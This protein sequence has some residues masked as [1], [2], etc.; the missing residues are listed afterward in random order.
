VGAELARLDSW[1]V[2][3]VRHVHDHGEVGLEPVRHHAR[4]VGADLLLHSRHTGDR[5]GVTAGLLH[6][7]RHLD[8]HE[9]AEPIVERPRDDPLAPQLDRFGGDDDLVAG[10][11]ERA[12]LVAVLRADVDVE[13]LHLE[14]LLAL[15]G[16][17]EVR[18]LAADDPGQRP[19]ASDHVDALPDQDLPVPAAGLDHAQVALV[20]HVAHEQRDLVDVP[21]DRHQR[22]V[23][24]AVNAGDGRPELVR[25]DLVREP[26]GGL[27]PDARRLALVSGRAGRGQQAV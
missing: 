6:A 21:D 20:G 4:A 13:V 15:V 23:A 18:R 2:G 9:H 3:G 25:R 24:A 27:A 10:P 7:P 26:L 22:A 17:G 5:P 12:R 11:D 14:R 16:I 8:G 19:V 1:R